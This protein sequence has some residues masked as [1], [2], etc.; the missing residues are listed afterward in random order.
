MYM[1]LNSF[2]CLALKTT[3]DSLQICWAIHVDV[4]KNNELIMITFLCFVKSGHR[5]VIL[6]SDATF[7]IIIFQLIFPISERE[8]VHY[9]T[10]VF[11]SE[12]KTVLF[13]F[14]FPIS[15]YRRISS[16]WYNVPFFPTCFWPMIIIALQNWS[17]PI[18]FIK[19]NPQT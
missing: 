9:V 4:W 18:K 1:C 6:V 14:L 11:R 10:T 5:S 16:A 8:N 15:Y 17:I 3:N 2:D 13:W 12:R 19:N 7:F